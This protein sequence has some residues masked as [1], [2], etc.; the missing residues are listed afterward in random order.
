VDARPT[1]GWQGLHFVA[2]R[3]LLSPLL[4]SNGRI[5]F[6]RFFGLAS[7]ELGAFLAGPV[8]I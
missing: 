1:K 8:F 2:F 6:V 4:K 7:T 5:G 3:R